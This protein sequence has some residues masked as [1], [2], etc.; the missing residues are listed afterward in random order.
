[1]PSLPS[2]L[3]A[4]RTSLRRLAVLALLALLPAAP[5]RA[6]T[7]AERSERIVAFEHQGNARPLEAAAALAS[8][9]EGL[10]D[11]SAAQVDALAVQGW[12]LAT[13]NDAEAAERV[14]ARI[15]RLGSRGTGSPKSTSAADVAAASAGLVRARI[16]MQGGSLGRA[17]RLL[18]DAT[19]RLPRVGAE[20]LQLRL[21]AAW[22]RVKEESGQAEEAVRHYLHALELADRL[23]PDWRRAD[24]RRQL[25][26]LTAQTGQ[27]ERAL[28][29]NQEAL[30]LAHSD[31]DQMLLSLIMNTEG[32][33]QGKVGDK[34]A[35]LRAMHSAID[36]AVAARAPRQ[37]ALMLAN[38]ADYHLRAGEYPVAMDYA[39][40]ALPLARE[41]KDTD[42]ELVALANRGLA[43][44]SMRRFDEG[45]HDLDAAYAID[46]RRG[47]LSGMSLTLDEAGRYL[48]RAG[49][50]RGALDAYLRYR[51]LADQLFQRDQQK[52]MLELQESF[53][54]AQRQRDLALLQADGALQR[55]RLQAQSL[56]TR[57]WLLAT[58]AAVLALAVMGLLA[59]RVRQS[60]AAL[61]QVNEQ[62]KVQ[63]ECDPLTGLA[64]RRRFQ[65]AMQQQAAD[66]R[67]RGS[68]FLIDIDHFKRINDRFGHAAGDQVLVEIARRLTK[69]VRTGDLVVRWGGEEFLVVARDMSA[70]AVEQM[71]QRVLDGIAGEPV[72][73][74]GHSI[75]V[76]ASVGFATYPVEP[77]LIAPSWERAIDLVDTALYLAKAH[78]RNRGY[79]V[80]SLQAAHETELASISSALEDAWRA[81]RVALTLLQG[82]R[83]Q[84]VAP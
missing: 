10:E 59:R 27:T 3:L 60:N 40:R 31:D 80:R 5:A 48:E 46:E 69:A 1:M 82:P 35:E 13:A 61:A 8:M 84:G 66:G 7:A 47:S 67:L 25:A 62:L 28:A 22:A 19:R 76:S 23:G 75:G 18:G 63:S 68:V 20:L 78:G 6:E 37:Q 58:L 36:H 74:E 45:K 9:V 83:T 57:V 21:A 56:Q 2:G 71:A 29:L 15:D 52:A 49:D 30:R 41:L 16:Q 64:N 32:F 17:D 70:D 14:A 81:G 51:P 79:G 24:V 53:D 43:L 4:P 26:W 65:T 55:E 72:A 42:V 73:F 38:M 50:L 54:H 44:V 33:I 12:L 34:A 11:G 39:E 77:S